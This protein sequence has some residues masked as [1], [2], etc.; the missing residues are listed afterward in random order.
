MRG[1]NLFAKTISQVGK[2][3]AVRRHYQGGPDPCRGL[4]SVD[5]TA[6]TSSK[7]CEVFC[8]FFFRF[9]PSPI[10]VAMPGLFPDI[11][12]QSAYEAVRR[13]SHGH[14]EIRF[15]LYFTE[16]LREGWDSQSTE[17]AA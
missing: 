12:V 8:T 17:V 6:P 14:K 15:N 9:L 4:E 16:Q 7:S 5:R 10:D 13:C 3:Q 2:K 11:L 1:V